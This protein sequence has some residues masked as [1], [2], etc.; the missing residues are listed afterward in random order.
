[1][2]DEIWGGGR[3]P[4]SDTLLLIVV[5]LLDIESF[6][7]SLSDEDAIVTHVKIYLKFKSGM[8]L[9]CKMRDKFWKQG[10]T[11]A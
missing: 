1:M 9:L 4:G 3:G 2:R 11:L 5:I 8:S 7:Y 10:S 6:P